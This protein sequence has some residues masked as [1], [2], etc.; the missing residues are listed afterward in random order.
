MTPLTLPIAELKP[1]NTPSP[2]IEDVF[3]KLYQVRESLQLNVGKLKDLTSKWRFIH[4][5]QRTND[6]AVN[7][8]CSNLRS[9]QS[10]KL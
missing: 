3:Q 9:L 10:L 6:K 2:K 8:L 1:A 4:W 5:E 7:M